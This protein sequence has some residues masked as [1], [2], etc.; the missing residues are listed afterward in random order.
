M[1][2]TSETS[3]NPRTMPKSAPAST[4]KSNEPGMQK[5]CRSMYTHAK[6]V[7][8]WTAC[9]SVWSR[10]RRC[11]CRRSSKVRGNSSSAIGSVRAITTSTTLT[12]RTTIEAACHD[13]KPRRA[14]A[15]RRLNTRSPAF[16]KRV[17]RNAI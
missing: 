6:P 13:A 17:G 14:L 2:A 3:T 11:T 9:L 12:R 4:V 7:M 15:A 10:R 16:M 1:E 5:V 8:L